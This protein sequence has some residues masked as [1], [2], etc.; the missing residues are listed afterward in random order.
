MGFEEDNFN[1]KVYDQ[2]TN[3]FYIT[4]NAT[5]LEN[6]FPFKSPTA[7]E[8][9]Q[10]VMTFE[11]EAVPLNVSEKGEEPAQPTTEDSSDSDDGGVDAPVDLPAPVQD[12]PIEIPAPA[13]LPSPPAPRQS[14][15]KRAKVYY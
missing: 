5:F 3:K 4:H 10:G 12:Q 7:G 2:S 15:M 13:P 9:V 1:Y 11:D 8:E 14:A 6:V